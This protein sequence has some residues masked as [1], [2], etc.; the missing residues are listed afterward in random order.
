MTLNPHFQ[1]HPLPGTTH[2]PFKWPSKYLQL[3]GSGHLTPNISPQMNLLLYSPNPCLLS[4]SLCLLMSLMISWL[5]R[6]DVLD[7]ALSSPC[8]CFPLFSVTKSDLF[9]LSHLYPAAESGWDHGGGEER[10]LF[11][12]FIIL[13]Q[14]CSTSHLHH[15]LYIVTV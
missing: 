15:S 6:L 13:V 12:P 4:K 11:S 14:I 8:F 10:T 1:P 7:S 5:L 9:F 2:P 3:G